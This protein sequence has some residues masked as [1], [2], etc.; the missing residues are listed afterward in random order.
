MEVASPSKTP[1]TIS[2]SMRRHRPPPPNRF[3]IKITIGTS[4]FTKL[5]LRYVTLRCRSL[6]LVLSQYTSSL[7]WLL[8]SSISPPPPPA[9]V[10]FAALLCNLERFALCDC[11]GY[12]VYRSAVS[13]GNKDTEVIPYHYHFPIGICIL[14]DPYHK[15]SVS[16]PH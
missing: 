11:Q 13:R 5:I 8:W 7:N 15:I 6:Q 16:Y 2:N 4:N 12:D 10:R 14:L 3:F 1:V 9:T